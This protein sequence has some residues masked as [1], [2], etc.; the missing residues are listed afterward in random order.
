MDSV[1]DDDFLRG[2]L[3]VRQKTVMQGADMP[4]CDTQRFYTK[5]CG[6]V[7]ICRPDMPHTLRSPSGG[8]LAATAPPFLATQGLA[9]ATGT[10]ALPPRDPGFFRRKSGKEKVLYEKSQTRISELP[11][12]YGT[13]R[14]IGKNHYRREP[15]KGR[16]MVPGA[17]LEP[18]GKQI[19]SLLRVP[20]RQPGT[21]IAL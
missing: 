9:S 17:G 14:Q 19:L 15:V 12:V 5:N 7:A 8:L 10:R 16:N 1:A 20:F 13:N 21:F 2:R 18:A 3:R 11:R 4:V 6:T